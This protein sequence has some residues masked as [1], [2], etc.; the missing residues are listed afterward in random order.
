MPAFSVS[1]TGRVFNGLTGV[2]SSLRPF[3]RLA[4]EQIGGVDVRCTQP[5]LLAFLLENRITQ[6]A[7]YTQSVAT[8]ILRG[9]AGLWGRGA[10]PGREDLSSGWDVLRSLDLGSD[11]FEFRELVFTGEFYAALLDLCHQ[12]GISLENKNKPDEA[13]LRRTKDLVLQEVLA[14]RGCYHHDFE[15]AFRERFPTTWGAVRQI[16][17]RHY[18]TLIRI[19][20]RLESWVV[21]E[22]VAPLLVDKIPIVTLHDAIYGRVRDLG[23]IDGAF[24]EVFGR[25]GMCLKTKREIPPLGSS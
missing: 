1:S 24:H 10:V 2:K 16:N 19:L 17:H 15:K 5:A 21:I 4:D 6:T 18:A 7:Q 25:L 3:V 13:E 22:N 23:T 8:Y 20:Q 11:F 9:F 12:K 14:K